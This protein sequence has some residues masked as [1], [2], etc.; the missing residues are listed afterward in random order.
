MASLIKVDDAGLNS[1]IAQSLASMAF[2]SN[3]N[4]NS[5]IFP[6]KKNCV[7]VFEIFGEMRKPPAQF[8]HI[9]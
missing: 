7:E 3:F 8:S 4:R 5:R 1:C 9:C 6:L 2:L